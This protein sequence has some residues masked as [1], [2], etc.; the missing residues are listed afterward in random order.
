MTTVADRAAAQ[1]AAEEVGAATRGALLGASR[2]LP[3]DA[4]LAQLVAAWLEGSSVLPAWLGLGAEEYA[5][6]MARHFP[7]I[8]AVA[9]EPHPPAL[10]VP[11]ADEQ[12]DVADLM[13]R[14]R[15]GADRSELWLAWI[16]AAGCLG[17]EHLWRDLGLTGRA[18]LSALIGDAFP[19]LRAFNARDMKWKKFL[20]KR[21]CEE[22]GLY[23]C[24]AP[25]CD[26]CSDF[27]DCFGPEA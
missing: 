1:A 3:N 5:A 25:S 11:L 21:L 19:A 2:G 4:L 26:A 23:T 22:T 20:Y 16:V 12:G 14:Y 18:E 8:G 27:H 9:P 17:R 7:R 10:S 24:R 15:R 13:I 6:L